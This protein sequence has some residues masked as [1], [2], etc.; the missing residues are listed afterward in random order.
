MESEPFYRLVPRPGKRYTGTLTA[1]AI[2]KA[3][4]GVKLDSQLL[5][6]IMQS[7]TREELRKLLI[8]MI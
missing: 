7:E 4:L 3:F 8:A 6:F 1:P 5:Q 2:D